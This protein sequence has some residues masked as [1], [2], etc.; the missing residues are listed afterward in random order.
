MKHTKPILFI[1]VSESENTLR[2][3]EGFPPNSHGHLVA[4]LTQNSNVLNATPAHHN[5]SNPVQHWRIT[6]L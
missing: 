2:K 6:D 3:V 1:F 4:D 5:A